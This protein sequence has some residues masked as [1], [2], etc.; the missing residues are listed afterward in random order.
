MGLHV[1]PEDSV[2]AGLVA[3]VLAEPLQ[4]VGVEAH[5]HNGFAGRHD[6]FGVFPEGCVGGARFRVGGNALANAASL[7]LRSLPQ[8]VRRE[9]LVA[10][11]RALDALPVVASFLG[12]RAPG[13]DDASF[14]VFCVRINQG[15][16]QAI[17]QADGVGAVLAVIEAVVLLFDG[18]TFED[19]YSVRESYAVQFEVAAILAFVPSVAH[20]MYLHNVNMA[21][22]HGFRCD[23]GVQALRR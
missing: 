1:G 18:W 12:F 21:V 11:R 8:L 5:G 6:D 3:G 7:L 14:V 17:H 9:L 15:N 2:D 4:Q 23:G 10:A 16:F 22:A 20:G 13:R 19:P